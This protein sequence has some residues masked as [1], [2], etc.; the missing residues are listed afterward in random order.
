MKPSR[1]EGRGS[2]YDSYEE[3]KR[4]KQKAARSRHD[5]DKSSDKSSP[6]EEDSDKSDRKGRNA[7]DSVPSDAETKDSSLPSKPSQRPEGLPD[8]SRMRLEDE[9]DWGTVDKSTVQEDKKPIEE[10]LIVTT[11]KKNHCGAI[12]TCLMAGVYT[13]DGIE[14]LGHQGKRAIMEWGTTPEQLESMEKSLK[15]EDIIDNFKNDHSGYSQVSGSFNLDG[16]ERERTKEMSS[17]SG[18]KRSSMD[19]DNKNKSSSR[20]HDRTGDQDPSS[21]A[22]ARSREN[23]GNRSR[24]YE[25][26][27]QEKR[28]GE[29]KNRDEGRTHEDPR[30][31]DYKRDGR[32]SREY[33]G[34]KMEGQRNRAN[35]VRREEKLTSKRD[36]ER[37]R[38]IESDRHKDQ[39]QGRKGSRDEADDCIYGPKHKDGKRDGPDNYDKRQYERD[40]R[41]DSNY[42]KGR[43][44][45]NSRE[46]D[47]RERKEV[48]SPGHEGRYGKKRDGRESQSRRR[49]EELARPG[50]PTEVRSLQLDKDEGE[51]NNPNAGKPKE[52]SAQEK[53]SQKHIPIPSD[54]ISVTSIEIPILP[55]LLSNQGD[56]DTLSILGLSR[57]N[58][59]KAAT[60]HQNETGV[61]PQVQLK[62]GK[63][64]FIGKF[65]SRKKKQA[66]E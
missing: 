11:L 63:P 5:D 25:T 29:R 27:D 56:D 13:L 65:L 23:A 21:E 26:S 34:K 6:T 38:D 55:S 2:S 58:T 43:N 1:P 54:C 17:R 49:D 3:L 32:R 48:E 19:F 39:L 51:N 24:R 20:S 50:T 37:R 59:H 8:V 57:P 28:S 30:D 33:E 35:E 15:D 46:R 64:S 47:F 40:S 4:L 31:M 61:V 52:H 9:P 36:D 14:N 18:G 62:K 53:E 12:A 41:G 45:E 44:Y 42:G 22:M 7:A 60:P 10:P 66:G 16:V